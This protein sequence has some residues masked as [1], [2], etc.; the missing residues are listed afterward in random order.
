MDVSAEQ[1]PSPSDGDAG[2]IVVVVV[3]WI[4]ALVVLAGAWMA[5]LFASPGLLIAI[6]LVFTAW[7]CAVPFLAARA[8]EDDPFLED[9]A[10]MF[11]AMSVGPLFLVGPAI[12]LAGLLIIVL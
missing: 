6:G 2:P 5:A 3:A 8:E 1:A 10:A 4:S 12:C 7:I 11:S 9:D